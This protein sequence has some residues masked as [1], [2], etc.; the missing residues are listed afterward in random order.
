MTHNLGLKLISFL[1]A[2]AIWYKVSF[3]NPAGIVQKYLCKVSVLNRDPS[4]TV[5]HPFE[6]K[7][8]HITLAG[9]RWDLIQAEPHLE[10]VLDLKNAKSPIG[11]VTVNLEAVYPPHLEIKVLK[12]EPRVVKI[13][14]L[15]AH[16]PVA[17]PASPRPTSKPSS[18]P[19]Y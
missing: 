7:R 16:E 8:V 9:K 2:L 1:I 17:P 11:E 18:P 6:N 15:A 3:S 4:L 13:S 12:I 19:P 5:S 14:V 10:A